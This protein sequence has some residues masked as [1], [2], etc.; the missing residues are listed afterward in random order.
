[1]DVRP[2]PAR[3]TSTAMSDVEFDLWAALPALH[4]DEG[5][6]FASDPR[7]RD[8]GEFSPIGFFSILVRDN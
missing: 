1:M 5:P 4:S 6:P 3:G 7:L 8:F 2:Q